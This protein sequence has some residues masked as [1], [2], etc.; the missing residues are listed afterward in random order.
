MCLSGTVIEIWRL[1]IYVHTN[2]ERWIHTRTDGQNNQSLNLLQCS[3]RSL[4]GDNY[5]NLLKKWVHLNCEWL[6]ANATKVDQTVQTSDDL[7][8][9]WHST[10]IVETSVTFSAHPV[11][12]MSNVICW[13]ANKK[14]I[15]IITD[16]VLSSTKVRSTPIF[17]ARQ[18]TYGLVHSAIPGHLTLRHSARGGSGR[19]CGGTRTQGQELKNRSRG[20]RPCNIEGASGV[21]QTNKLSTHHT[22][23]SEK[24]HLL[25][26]CF[27]SPWK[28][29]RFPEK[30]QE[31]F[32]RKQVFHRYKS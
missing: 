14:N 11:Y 22:L 15:I 1:K 8:F 26:F 16:L 20:L 10:D 30:F 31:M 27:I 4:G 12:Q 3:I 9:I 17:K 28:M 5:K 24:R 6:I 29:F 2:T 18:K 21:L 19:Q 13:S 7:Q 25:T 23:C 32:R